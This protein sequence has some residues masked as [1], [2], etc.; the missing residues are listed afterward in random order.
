MM[1]GENEFLLTSRDIASYTSKGHSDVLRDIRAEIEKWNLSRNVHFIETFYVSK[2]NEAR[3]MY[4]IT[5]K[6]VII[7]IHRYQ[8]KGSVAVNKLKNIILNKEKE[9]KNV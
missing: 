5:R 4:N 1:K 7:L 8:T 9:N 2:S 3:P 6:G